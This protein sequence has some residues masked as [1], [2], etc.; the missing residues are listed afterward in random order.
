M[1]TKSIEKTWRY[2]FEEVR[3]YTKA[4]KTKMIN[5]A[6]WERNSRSIAYDIASAEAVVVK[7]TN[8]VDLTMDWLHINKDSKHDWEVYLY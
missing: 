3:D 6:K 8:S 4:M 2:N 5:Y 1:S 7:M